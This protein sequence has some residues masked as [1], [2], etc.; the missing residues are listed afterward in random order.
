MN[1]MVDV[2]TQVGGILEAMEVPGNIVLPAFEDFARVALDE[3][4]LGT[5]SG[6]PWPVDTGISQD[7]W[8]SSVDFDDQS[9][10]VSFFNAA[11]TEPNPRT[12]KGGGRSYAAY[13]YRAGTAN[14]DNNRVWEE[15]ENFIIENLLPSLME[16]CIQLIL[17]SGLEV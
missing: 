4:R 11:R 16:E 12:G 13:I 7:S 2:E 3:I 5:L 6:N 15:K 17:Q 1:V 10:T 9:I 8:I 14:D